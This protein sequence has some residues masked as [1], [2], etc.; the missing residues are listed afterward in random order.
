MHDDAP[1]Q[2]ALALTEAVA[3]QLDRNLLAADLHG[4]HQRL[5]RLEQDDAAKAVRLLIMAATLGATDV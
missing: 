2:M 5:I 3:Q 1:I 4:I